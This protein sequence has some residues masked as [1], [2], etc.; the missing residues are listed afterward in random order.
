MWPGHVPYSEAEKVS[1]AASP[2]LHPYRARVMKRCVLLVLFLVLSG[3]AQPGPVSMAGAAPTQEKPASDPHAELL[4]HLMVAELAG[5]RGDLDQASREY[6]RA[7]EL[8]PDP[9]IAERATRVALYADKGDLALQSARRWLTLAPGSD[10]AH[11]AIGLLYLRR[12]DL[13]KATENFTASIPDDPTQ[14]EQALA[15]MGAILA[16]E[17]DGD[18]AL[19]VMTR[20]ADRY[21]KVRTAYYAVAQVALETGKPEQ[22]VTALDKVLKVAPGWRSAE[23]L[24]VDA[25]LALNR[26]AEA[27][28]ALRGLLAKAPKDYDLRLQYA[29]ALVNLSRTDKA[30]EQFQR[31][32]KQRPDD[33]R[34]LY[35]A[36]LLAMEADKPDLAKR[37]FTRLLS[38]GNRADAARYYLGRIAEDQQ[39]YKKALDL[40]SQAAGR[41]RVDAQLRIAITLASEGSL[42]EARKRLVQLREGNPDAAV[43]AY[44]VEGDILRTAGRLQ[45]SVDLYTTALSEHPGDADLL[46]GRALT[47]VQMNR[48]AEGEQDLR[49]ILKKDP[50]NAQALNALGYTLAD[51]T[52]RYR[53]AEPLIRKAYTLRPDD[54]AV[55]DSMGWVAYRMGRL[56]EARDYLQRAYDLSRHE[57][58][59]AA[60]LGEVLW[61]LDRRTQA[62]HIWSDALDKHPDNDV[63]Q[64]TIQRLTQ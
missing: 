21:P 6:T 5:A 52:Q 50:D 17:S 58:E 45:E 27:L 61:H 1:I 15:R 36:G 53:E 8:S 41:Y 37:W 3:C 9:A 38:Q 59:I 25:L 33:D 47:Y 57:P 54:P 46:Y 44:A 56:D 7:A 34:V 63:L 49:A 13:D 32:L 10:E 39:Q 4:Y 26:S 14:E 2:N 31:L 43:R 64:E 55:I 12:G 62:R 29:R 19:Q 11:R 16:Q 30:L 22:A 42:D 20:V 48:V 28:D 40:Y 23:L 60:H 18:G 51:Q 24:R 35:A